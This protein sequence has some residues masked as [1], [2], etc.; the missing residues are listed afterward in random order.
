M[1][2]GQD[3]KPQT[4]IFILSWLAPTHPARRDF[5]ITAVI[6]A[7]I[8]VAATATMIPGVA[9]SQSV[10]SASTMDTLSG[11]VANALAIQIELNLQMNI[12]VNYVLVVVEERY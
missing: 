2:T 10:A 4:T 5:G 1:G 9:I 3:R 12:T 6:L 7:A 8:A 11:Q